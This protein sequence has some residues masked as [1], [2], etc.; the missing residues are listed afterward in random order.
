MILVLISSN[1]II[2]LLFLFSLNLLLNSSSS[3][4]LFIFLVDVFIS[5]SFC[6]GKLI[7]LFS[8]SKDGL[9][10][11][12]LD[13]EI[14]KEK[15]G[16]SPNELILNALSVILISIMGFLIGYKLFTILM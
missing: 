13:F 14:G 16:F 7:K 1:C 3:N 6:S 2:L 5:N 4:F 11:F 9:K 12:E 8:Y 10:N 15:S